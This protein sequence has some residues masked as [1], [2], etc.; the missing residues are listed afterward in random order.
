VLALAE[1]HPKVRAHITIDEGIRTGDHGF[2]S[3]DARGD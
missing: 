2:D 3:V 1:A